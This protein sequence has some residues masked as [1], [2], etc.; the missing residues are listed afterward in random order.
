MKKTK[1]LINGN[2]C[3]IILTKNPERKFRIRETDPTS[4]GECAALPDSG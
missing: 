4:L 2:K 1:Y 3:S